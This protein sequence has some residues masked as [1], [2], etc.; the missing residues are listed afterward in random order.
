MTP[1][2]QC[3]VANEEKTTLSRMLVDHEDGDD[4]LQLVGSLT[5][6]IEISEEDNRRLLRK[7]DF[8]LLPLMGIL[9]MCSDYIPFV[10]LRSPTSCRRTT[11]CEWRVNTEVIKY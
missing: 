3:Y 2:E 9:C 7:I 4:A 8:C 1:D 10:D 11:I 5:Q 6:G